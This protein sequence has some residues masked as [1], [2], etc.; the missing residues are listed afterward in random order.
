MGS[1]FS[2]SSSCGI[3]YGDYQDASD[4]LC[5]ALRFP[6]SIRGLKAGNVFFDLCFF[7]SSLYISPSSAGRGQLFARGFS[8]GLDGERLEAVLTALAR[9][10]EECSLITA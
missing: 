5:F 1:S 8:A 2:S 7:D 10:G 3:A 4:T 6:S 9:L